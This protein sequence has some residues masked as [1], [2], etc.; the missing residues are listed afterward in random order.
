MF[1]LEMFEKNGE[2]WF[3]PWCTIYVVFKDFFFMKSMQGTMQFYILP[4]MKKSILF[5]ITEKKFVSR[6]YT[7]LLK[8]KNF[9]CGSQVGHIWVTSRLFCGSVG[10]MGQQV[11]LTFNPVQKYIFHESSVISKISC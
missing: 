2:S 5:H 10:Q 9:M 7:L 8:R 3:M 6:Y 11:Q 4:R 1:A